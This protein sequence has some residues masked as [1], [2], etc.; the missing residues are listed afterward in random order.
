M[1]QGIHLTLLV[2]PNQP[3]PAPLPLLEALQEVEV[4]HNDSG[5]SGFQ[6][7]FQT[8]QSRNQFRDQLLIA[9][10]RLQPFSRVVIKVTLN[11]REQ[12]L[13]DG[14]ITNHQLSPSLEVGGSTLT[15]TGED[16]SVM[17]DLEEKSEQHPGQNESAIVTQLIGNYAKYGL[18]PN[19]INPP[20]IDQPSPNDRVPAQQGTDLDY[21]EQLAQRYAYVFYLT[22][23]PVTGKSIAYWGPPKRTRSPQTA[24]TL[25]MSSFTNVES[26]N[27]QYNALSAQQVKGEF[28]DRKTNQIELLDFARSDRNTPLATRAGLT[29]QPHVRVQQYRESGNDST[30]SRARGQAIVDRSTDNVVTASGQLDTARYGELL[31]LRGIIRLR[32]AGYTH[33]GEYYIKSVTHKIRKG[34]YK[35]SFTLTREGSG[36]TISSV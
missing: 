24:L 3:A 16:V 2:G 29:R 19:V 32:G 5:R 9:D 23:G 18:I 17:M 6:L 8:G 36:S 20:V 30:R 10:P 25:N 1:L 4:T 11:A 14:V 34:E 21:I 31:Q 13:M 35:Q 28:Q 27:F 15:L 26:L 33:D 12:I 22:P 7:V